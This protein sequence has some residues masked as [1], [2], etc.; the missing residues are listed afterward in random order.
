MR[1]LILISIFCLI[2]N[3]VVNG[4]YSRC[5]GTNT[6]ACDYGNSPDCIADDCCEWE[7]P[8]PACYPKD[9]TVLADDATCAD[10][11]G[12]YRDSC[13]F[14][15]WGSNSFSCGG[16]SEANC[17]AGESGKCCYWDEPGPCRRLICFNVD[18][19]DCAT[20]GCEEDWYIWDNQNCTVSSNT[21]IEGKM[22][23]EDGTVT[24]NNGITL[25]VDDYRI[26]NTG[27]GSNW[28]R[29]YGNLRVK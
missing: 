2:F 13:P 1:I 8:G 16:L 5:T 3:P 24:V 28:I 15:C 27:D 17:E 25:T 10:C 6:E 7:A 11:S 4:V 26:H 9:C 18:T 29:N 19:A 12:C 21:T 14:E 20:C 22:I 23:I